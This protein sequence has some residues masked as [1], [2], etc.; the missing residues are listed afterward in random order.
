MK[1]PV[2]VL[3]AVLF[4]PLACSKPRNEPLEALLAVKKNFIEGKY[5]EAKVMM[6]SGTRRSLGSLERLSP[7]IG[8]TGYGLSML[9]ADGSEWDVLENKKE[10]GAAVIRVR[11]ARHPVENLRGNEMTFR[12]VNEGGRWKLDLENMIDESVKELRER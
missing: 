5:V 1:Y 9:F 8:E 6:T 3:I 4:L 10:N 12:L 7:G 11:Y 2:P